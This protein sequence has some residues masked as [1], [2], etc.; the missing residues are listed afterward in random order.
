ML[1]RGKWY[2]G[3]KELNKGDILSLDARAERGYVYR[4]LIPYAPVSSAASSAIFSRWENMPALNSDPGLKKVKNSG[5]PLEST[6]SGPLEQVSRRPL[7]IAANTRL[8]AVFD[9]HGTLLEPTWKEEY[10]Q[11]YSIL[12][13]KSYMDAVAWV[14]SLTP[15][16]KDSQV[17]GIFSELSGFSWEETKK[18]FMVLRDSVRKKLFPKSGPGS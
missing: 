7:R 14:N 1:W 17:I 8:L 6:S 18:L 12:S 4:G 3:D 9:V 2:L 15:E 10:A 5:S 11:V 16:T 13:G